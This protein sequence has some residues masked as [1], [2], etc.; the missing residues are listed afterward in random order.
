M[1]YVVAEILNYM[2][3]ADFTACYGSW[4]I[5]VITASD[6]NVKFMESLQLPLENKPADRLILDVRIIGGVL[7]A[8][9]SFCL[10]LRCCA[11]LCFAVAGATTSTEIGRIFL[12]KASICR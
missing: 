7:Q 8:A 6:E 4:N 12:N 5:G 10:E 9:W 3:E 11:V 1:N 2:S